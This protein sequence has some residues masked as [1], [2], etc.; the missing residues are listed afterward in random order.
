MSATLSRIEDERLA[1]ALAVLLALSGLALANLAVEEGENG[2]LGPFA[3]GAVL[4]IVVAAVL[5]GRVL[6]AASR[7]VR[8][9][10]WLAG[11]SVLA[12]AAF[13]S[14][15]PMV[16]GVAAAYAGR[17]ASTVAPVAIGLASTAAALVACAL[18]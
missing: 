9:A 16:L 8:A 17:R 11:L 3:I 1:G 2:G 18:G 4:S 13:W 10:W 14:G 6:P 12:L 7:P 15:L 5:F